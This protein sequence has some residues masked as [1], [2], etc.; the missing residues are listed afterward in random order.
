M[1]TVAS[2]LRTAIVNANLS[3]VTTKVFRDLA[4]DNISTPFVTFTDDLARSP[5][6]FGDSAVLARDRMVQ[7]DLWQDLDSEDVD[8]VDSLL[9][10]VDNATLVG[11]DKT[12]FGCRVD[13]IARLADPPSNTCQHALTV[14]LTQG[15]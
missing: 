4:P 9:A 7:V 5:A 2:A 12:I 15:A 6:L 8:L 11:A 3:N 1:A 10:A 13:G 14:T